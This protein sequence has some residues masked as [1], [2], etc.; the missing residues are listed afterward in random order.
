[1]RA[2]LPFALYN[3]LVMGKIRE[4]IA[5]YDIHYVWAS[6]LTNIPAI[7]IIYFMLAIVI[8]ANSEAFKILFGI[9]ESERV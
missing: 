4:A 2:F 9:R 8:V 7:F 6:L 3:Y 1:M 5:Q